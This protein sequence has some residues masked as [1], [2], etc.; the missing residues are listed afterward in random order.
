MKKKRK[1]IYAKSGNVDVKVMDGFV[2]LDVTVRSKKGETRV[3]AQLS[4]T[5]VGELA[6]RCTIAFNMAA[7][8]CECDKCDCE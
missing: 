5:M 7:D 8:S 4:K 6:D 2:F 3:L 1:T